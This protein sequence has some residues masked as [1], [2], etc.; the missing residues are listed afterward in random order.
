MGVVHRILGS[1]LLA[2]G[3]VGIIWVLG[4]VYSQTEGFASVHDLWGPMAF[5][6]MVTGMG[7]CLVGKPALV[8][9]RNSA[10]PA[11]ESIEAK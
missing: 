4:G 5:H 3:L 2:A 11:P 9:A 7:T 6:A 8:K 1:L 10:V